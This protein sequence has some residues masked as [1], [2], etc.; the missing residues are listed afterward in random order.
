MTL[1]RY[2][3]SLFYFRSFENL[4]HNHTTYKKKTRSAGKLA[5]LLSLISNRRSSWM[6][7]KVKL[8]INFEIHGHRAVG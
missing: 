8:N 4:C 7:E 6:D 5:W 1:F 2:W 3:L